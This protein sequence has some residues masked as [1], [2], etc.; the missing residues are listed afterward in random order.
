MQVRQLSPRSCDVV[1]DPKNV[2]TDTK[3][4]LS[5][6]RDTSTLLARV[7]DERV[8]ALFDSFN[9][10]GEHIA[11]CFMSEWHEFDLHLKLAV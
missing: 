10:Q 9:R 1:P 4:L 6:L 11:L 2:V 5:I 8:A 7:Q 3:M